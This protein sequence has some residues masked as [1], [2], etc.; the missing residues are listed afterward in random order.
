MQA[1]PLPLPRLCEDVSFPSSPEGS[2]Y[3]WELACRAY[4]DGRTKGGNAGTR[5]GP[6][7]AHPEEHWGLLMSRL[8]YF[9]PK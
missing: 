2:L 5:G 9:F 6:G 8:L 4:P 3:L 1:H 7:Q